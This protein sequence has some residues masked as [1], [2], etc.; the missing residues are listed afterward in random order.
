MPVV[1]AFGT[2]EGYGS[3]QNVRNDTLGG[4]SVPPCWWS[5]CQWERAPAKRSEITGR[6]GG[7]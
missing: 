3:P 5:Q 6:G 7:G 1:A 2:K 4:C